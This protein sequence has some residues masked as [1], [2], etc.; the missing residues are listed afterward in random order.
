MKK[1]RSKYSNPD[2]QFVRFSLAGH[3]FGLDVASVKEIIRYRSPEQGGCPPFAEGTVRVRSMIVPVI[4]LGKRFGLSAVSSKSSMILITSIDSII[5]GLIV[6][7]IS[8]V[9]LGA[10][11]FTLKPEGEGHPWDAVV[12][13]RVEAETGPIFILCA[14]ELLTNEEKQAL[15][16]PL[17]CAD[18]DRLK[19]ELGLKKPGFMC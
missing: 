18:I 5:A 2:F 14:Q 3:E 7:G 16:G 15:S 1:I 9:A 10:R 6:D 19:A 12:E 17:G 8:D 11:E 4:D 13:A